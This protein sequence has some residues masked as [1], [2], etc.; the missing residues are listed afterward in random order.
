MRIRCMLCC[1]GGIG[2]GVSGY[3]TVVFIILALHSSSAL[4]VGFGF[5]FRRPLNVRKGGVEGCF[6][7]PFFVL[8][9]FLVTSERALLFFSLYT[10][11]ESLSCHVTSRH[12][13]VIH[14]HTD[15]HAHVMNRGL[16]LDWRWVLGMGRREE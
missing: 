6:L 9:L 16:H 5:L 2:V 11:L 12:V 1:G 10:P 14:T 7:S 8:N 13:T 15:T 3:D 4:L